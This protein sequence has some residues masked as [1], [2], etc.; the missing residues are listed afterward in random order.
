M[1]TTTA[2]GSDKVAKIVARLQTR[3]GEGQF[4]EAQQQ[5]RVV[6]ARHSK[7]RN[8]A[9]AVDILASVAQAL[10][11]AGQGGSA[12][13]LCVALVDTYRQAELRP[14]AESRG[15]LLACLRLFDPAEP[16]RKKF[17]A[18]MISWVAAA[19]GTRGC[20]RVCR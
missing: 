19:L 6:A 8:H 10:L 1:A 13:D 3:I 11:R 12:G 9:A 18:E 2:G 14:D 20:C 16:T 5:A 7:A 17:I 4:Y 15:R